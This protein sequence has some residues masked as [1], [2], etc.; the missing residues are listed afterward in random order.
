MLKKTIRPYN[1]KHI[2]PM[3]V[4]GAPLKYL[5]LTVTLHFLDVLYELIGVGGRVLEQRLRKFGVKI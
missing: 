4:P 1:Y 5:H 2:K 3:S